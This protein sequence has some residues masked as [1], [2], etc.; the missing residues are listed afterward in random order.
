MRFLSSLIVLIL[1]VGCVDATKTTNENLATGGTA[2]I[3]TVGTLGSAAID[4]ISDTVDVVAEDIKEV[5]S[6]LVGP[7]GFIA[8]LTLLAAYAR[9]RW[10]NR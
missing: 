7:V 2:I 10:N 6:S 8:T 3:D 9:K 4:V 5:S 1:T